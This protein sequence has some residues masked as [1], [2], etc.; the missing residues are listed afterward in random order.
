MPPP[1][2]SESDYESEYWAESESVHSVDANEPKPLE[3]KPEEATNAI[4]GLDLPAPRISQSYTSPY[5]D[6]ATGAHADNGKRK[7]E[8]ENGDSGHAAKT[9]RTESSG[10]DS[11]L[12][13]SDDEE[14]IPYGTYLHPIPVVNGATPGS[15]SHA[16]RKSESLPSAINM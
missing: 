4:A 2:P 6:L 16:S 12:E 5:T 8:S 7:A 10:V 14:V 13:E 1:V 11:A 3:A 9:H 15:T